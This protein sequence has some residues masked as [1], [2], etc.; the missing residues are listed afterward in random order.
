MTVDERRKAY[1]G[2]ATLIAWGVAEPLPDAPPLYGDSDDY[3][4]VTEVSR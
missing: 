4:T 2:H 3:V 1:R